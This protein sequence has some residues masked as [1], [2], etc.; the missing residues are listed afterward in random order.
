MV[1]K[2]YDNNYARYARLGS[3]QHLPSSTSTPK[4]LLNSIFKKKMISVGSELDAYLHS[5]TAESDVDPLKWWSVNSSPYPTVSRMA[6]D[7]LTIAGHLQ[8]RRDCFRQGGKRAAAKWAWAAALRL[9]A[10]A[11]GDIVEDL[12][13]AVFTLKYR[14]LRAAAVAHLIDST[15]AT[16]HTALTDSL[17]TTA[18]ACWTMTVVAV[19]HSGTGECRFCTETLLTTVR[20][21]RC[22]WRESRVNWSWCCTS[23]HPHRGNPL[24]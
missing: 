13:R 7:Y 2:V 15:D 14:A 23:R 4:R 24:T 20:I 22:S 5:A 9:W 8:A 1:R 21:E 18:Q 16:L 19:L 6:R 17:H 3:D 10:A 12:K 11:T